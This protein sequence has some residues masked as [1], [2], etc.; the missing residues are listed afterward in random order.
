M[1]RPFSE[2]ERVTIRAQLRDKAQRLFETRGLRKTSVDEIAQAAGISKGAFYLFYESKEALCLDLLESIESRLRAS[3]LEQTLRAG[4]GARQR[5]AQILRS[6]LTSWEEY[7]LLRTFSQAD[8]AY[9]IRKLPPE[10]VQAHVAQDKAFV[11][12]FMARLKKE[13]I[14]PRAQPDVIVNLIRSLFWVGL[15]RD[16]LGDGDYTKTMTILTDLIA[17]HIVGGGR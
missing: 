8:Y 6:F 17:G 15:H 4:R 12:A 7:P 9:L 3:V 10:K 16:E 11:K 13:D 5:V 14:T 1:P 2:Q